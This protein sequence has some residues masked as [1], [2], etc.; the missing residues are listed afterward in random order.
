M[1]EQFLVLV[2]GLHF[3]AGVALAMV[4]FSALVRRP[5][6]GPVAA[7][8]FAALVIVVDWTA[9]HA[10][11]GSLVPATWSMAKSGVVSAAAGAAAGVVLTVLVFKPNMRTQTTEES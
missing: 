1:N 2:F 8:G 5:S 9:A 7:P 6:A 10:V 11:A 3:A 4:S